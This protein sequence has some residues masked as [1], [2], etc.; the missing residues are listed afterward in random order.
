VPLFETLFAFENFPLDASLGADDPSQP[1]RICG[2]RMIESAH[3]PLALVAQMQGTLSFRLQW[4]TPSVPVVAIERL[5]T[6]LKGLLMGL[7]GSPEK[8]PHQLRMLTAAEEEE[9]LG[10]AEGSDRP[11]T[12]G[13]PVHL[14]FRQQA[15]RRREAV[16]VAFGEEALTYG[17]LDR[18][19]DGLARYLLELG[20]EPGAR[21]AVALDRSPELVVAL[22]GILKAG[23]SYVPL[24]PESP[25]RRLRYILEDAGCRILLTREDLAAALPP[26]RE[27]LPI[28]VLLDQDLPTESETLDFPPPPANA[29]AYVIYTSG[30]TGWPKGVAVSH[31]SLSH[32]VA[33]HLQAFEVTAGD[34]GTLIAGPAF[35]AS[36]WEIWPYLCAG[37][38]LQVMSHEMLVPDLMPAFFRQHGISHAFVPTPLVEAMLRANRLHEAD[39]LK[40]LLTGG[41]RLL[42][43]PGDE[44]SFPLINNYGPTEATVVATS[45]E[46]CR[47]GEGPPAIGTPIAGTRAFVLD[48]SL[49]LVPRSVAG[50]L[51]LAG[52]T[53]AQGYLNRP[54]LTAVHFVPNPFS[55]TSGDRLYRTGD[56]ASWRPDG[57]LAYGGRLDHQIKVRG[58]RIEVGEIEVVLA[59]HEA[60]AE[61]VVVVDEGEAGKRLICVWASGVQGTS[62]VEAPSADELR[63]F[64][65][66][67]LPHYM[68]PEEFVLLAELPLTANGK[69]DRGAALEAVQGV[70]RPAQTYLPPQTEAEKTL[71]E[72]WAQAL[73]RQGAKPIGLGDNFFDVGGDSIVALQIVSRARTAGLQLR[74][75][76]LFEA[77]TLGQLAERTQSA[78]AL[79][80]DQGPVQ[81]AVPLTPIQHWFFEEGG[82]THHFNQ[83]QLLRLPAEVDAGYLEMA[84][85][86]LVNHHDA[87]R[88]RFTDSGEGWKQ[89]YGEVPRGE[90]PLVVHD[91]SRLVGSS[92]GGAWKRELERLAGQ[93]QGS[94]DLARPPLLRAVLFRRGRGRS[95]R[96][97]WVLH[98]LVVDGVSWR[99]LLEQ[100]IGAYEDVSLGRRPSLPARTASFQAWSHHLSKIAAKPRIQAELEGWKRA[101]APEGRLDFLPKGRDASPGTVAEAAHFELSL[102]EATTR[103]LLQEVPGVYRTEIND[104]LL[105]ALGRALGAWNRKSGR[106]G[107]DLLL[108]LEGHG[109]EEI[110]EESPDVSATVG[111]FTSAFP[112]RLPPSSGDAGRALKAVKECLRAIPHKGLGFGLLRYL[113]EE[114]ATQLAEFPPPQLSFNY[115]G[116]F[117]LGDGDWAL[118]QEAH[119]S[120]QAG[121]RRR[122]HLIDINA[123]VLAGRLRIT[124]T[125]SPQFTH[126]SIG[127]LAAAFQIKLER[128]IEHCLSPGSGGYSPSDFPLADLD[129]ERLETLQSRFPTLEDV[130]PLSPL[131]QGLLFQALYEPESS[132]Y[133][134]QVRLELKG[135]VRGEILRAAW[136]R[137]LDRHGN[138]RA[139]MVFTADSPPLQVVCAGVAVPWTQLDFSALSKEAGEIALEAWLRED[140]GRVFDGAEPLGPDPH[141]AASP[142]ADPQSSP[143]VDGRLV[144][145]RSTAGGSRPIPDFGGEGVGEP[146]AGQTL[147]RLYR[148]AP[149]ALG[150]GWHQFPGKSLLAALHRRPPGSHRVAHGAPPAR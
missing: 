76:D 20:V 59:R 7:V 38:S 113:G 64:A 147:S 105:C 85:R 55:R 92:G 33:W 108:T 17:E 83:S 122:A 120:V 18:R 142:R 49:N 104:V 143:C 79:V 130:F 112:V 63:S 10:L 14:Q 135:E 125:Y 119:G 96:L 145:P 103:S 69:F 8:R 35:D 27:G 148:L 88:L 16:A 53:L 94:L 115:L 132:A 23:G 93:V 140:R 25:Q 127:L 109:R 41:D 70:E 57:E 72:L 121:G 54:G 61:A 11:L 102:S 123:L 116:R 80:A 97:L 28:R 138:L 50:E 139:A 51:C 100:L 52:E 3:Y 4:H 71:A 46:V 144:P 128:L 78:S 37:A 2:A 40:Y 131:Q 133:F 39:T 73:G 65:V 77:P 117:D 110:G 81:G 129:E 34:R 19:S 91:L 86:A 90:G 60:V 136:Q 24:D 21:V 26:S 47:Q 67:F 29:C 43:R 124:F 30:S 101:L 6:H 12:V 98:H 149:A 95:T 9:L 82:G 15:Q 89:A 84:L 22:L 75:R 42:G 44:I 118:A 111:W 137:A 56:R 58:F 1:F 48:A 45:G 32:L 114:S 31:H 5:A 36:T 68:V 134:V 146:S 141:R 66:E 99:L 13:R 107:G 106:G 87:L 74:A 126:H 62:G 150:E